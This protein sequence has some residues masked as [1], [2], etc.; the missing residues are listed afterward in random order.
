[1]KSCF[2]R[3]ISL[4]LTVT[5]L[6]GALPLGTMAAEIS[7]PDIYTL[8]DGFLEVN[9]S[10]KNG[11]FHV[12]T[13]EGN[14]LNKDDNNK[15]LL[16]PLGDNDTSFTS[17]RVTRDGKTR[18]YIFGGKYS[19]LGLT[20][21]GVTVTQDAAGITAAWGVDDLKFTQRIELANS[22]SNN[23]GM[24]YISYKAETTGDRKSVV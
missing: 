8:S 11:G 10:K 14:K 1:M 21:Q 17:F 6:M 19:F 13:I 2:I 20:D 16:F 22:G 7:S 4:L 15:N 9:V 12:R 5:M 18:D 24:A 23:H 3:I